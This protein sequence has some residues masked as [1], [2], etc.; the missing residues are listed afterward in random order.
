MTTLKHLGYI[1]QDGPNRTQLLY[2]KDLLKPVSAF[3]GVNNKIIVA[4]DKSKK[5][6]N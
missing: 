4:S 2:N 5:A 6:N 3:M 1:F